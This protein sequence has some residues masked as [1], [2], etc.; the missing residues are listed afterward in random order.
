M[1]FKTIK[2]RWA[3]KLLKSKMFVILTEKESCIAI[4]GADPFSF[5][6]ALALAAQ[7]AELEM[8]HESLGNLVK[9][10]RNALAKLSGVP[11][12]EP[13]KKTKPIKETVAPKAKANATKASKATKQSR[14]VQPTV[15]GSKTP[16]KVTLEKAKK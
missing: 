12:N 13:A 15:R 5:T 11:T 6:D 2:I 7:A 16:S 3:S 8:F 14:P 1:S 4:D 10:H 9:D